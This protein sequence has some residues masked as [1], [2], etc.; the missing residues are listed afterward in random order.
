LIELTKI[1]AK[2]KSY[3]DFMEGYVA[4]AD[5]KPA[6]DGRMLPA[7][8]IQTNDRQAD[9]EVAE[10]TDLEENYLNKDG[11]GRS[12]EGYH[13]AGQFSKQQAQQHA[14]KHG[15]KV[16]ADPSGKY[17]V[18]LP[19]PKQMDEE[20][21]PAQKAAR[22]ALIKKTAARMA[23][24]AETDAKRAMRRDPDLKKP[25]KDPADHDLVHKEEVIA[26]RDKAN[27]LKRKTMDASRGARFKAQ[28]NHVPAPE[29]E[30]KTGQAHN[31]AIGR[32]I[33]QMSNEEVTEAKTPSDADLHKTLGPTKNMQQG[34]EALKKKH[35]MSDDDAKKHIRRLMG[36]KEGVELDESDS[37][38][39]YKTAANQAKNA[40]NEERALR[41]EATPNK[42]QVKQAIGIARDKRYAGGNMTGATKAMDKINKGLAQHPAVSKELQK[43]N[44]QLDPAGSDLYYE[45]LK[46]YKS[47]IKSYK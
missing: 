1:G 37:Q 32:A 40:T 30:H 16:S 17:L 46:T 15:G 10:E 18:K 13:D 7:R 12:K 2:M 27:A 22:L 34:V 23:K 36:M 43:Q 20:M 3:K 8:K 21:T 5:K 14:Q 47:F 26:E 29:P 28:G 31:K 45:E 33:R 38:Q 41:N 42:K 25:K 11:T 19:K 35:G 4:S 9:K 39:K 24:R 44:E 6:K